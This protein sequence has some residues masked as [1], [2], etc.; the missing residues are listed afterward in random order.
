MTTQREPETCMYCSLVDWQVDAGGIYNCPNPLCFGCGA[1]WFRGHTAGFAVLPN[2]RHT[3][4]T[5]EMIAFGTWL[6]GGLEPGATRDVV[7]RS[8]LEWRALLPPDAADQYD[9]G[10][11]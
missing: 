8:L 7:A 10:W 5:E 11:F 2:G 6:V 9:C 4:D 3:V 1:A